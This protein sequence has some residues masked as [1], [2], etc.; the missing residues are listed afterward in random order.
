MQLESTN[1]D[2]P[3]TAATLTATNSESRF[4]RHLRSA[5][6]SD[7]VHKV[8]ETYATR[9]LLSIAG[10]VTTVMIARL[11]GPEGRGIYAVAMTT[12]LLGVQFGNLGLHTA[13]VY[14]VAQEPQSLRSLTGNSLAISFGF[15]GLI[16]AAMAAL[17]LVYPGLI[18]L[19]GTMLALALIWIPFGLAYLLLQ[20]L[21]LGVHDVRGY[22]LL[23]VVS[24]LLP[25]ALIVG[26]IA[27][28][29]TDT[30]SLFATSLVALIL[31]CLWSWTRLQPRF[32][33]DRQW[34]SR[35]LFLGSVDYAGKAYMVAL[36]GFLVL[37]GDLFMV[38]HMLGPEQAGY[39]SIASSMADY[40]SVLATVVGFLLF[41]KLAAMKDVQAKLSMTWRAVWGTVALLLPLILVASVLAHPL[42]RLL[43]GVAFIPAA[44]AFVLLMP[45]M[46]F[47]SM[48][49]VAVQFLNSIG[50]PRQV[51]IN[52][53]ICCAANF[54]VNLWVIPRYGIAGASVV[55]SFSY[56]L[57]LILNSDVIRRSRFKLRNENL[58]QAVS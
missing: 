30:P 52:W 9:I 48:H 50:L 22:N 16:A 11:L 25:L 29:K 57:A 51:V 6:S 41:P 39:Y 49:A 5:R 23:E 2:A 17:F 26:L 7:F 42:V 32:D 24:K 37:R 34:M 55:S 3:V 45:G 54:L 43:F 18:S 15:G 47:L 19:R 36:L 20:H 13:N 40:V 46:L 53:S 44:S 38:Q 8:A 28:R 58:S 4:R 1:L 14:L 31:C 27:A 56:L 33:S 12:G 10:L 35:Q 21:M